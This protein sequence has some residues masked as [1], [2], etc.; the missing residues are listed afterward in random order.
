MALPVFSHFCCKLFLVI[1]QHFFFSYGIFCIFRNLSESD[2]GYTGGQFKN[3][4]L[5]FERFTILNLCK[6]KNKNFKLTSC[7][8]SFNPNRI[9]DAI[10]KFTYKKK[11]IRKSSSL[12]T[13]NDFFFCAKLQSLIFFQRD[14][15]NNNS[16]HSTRKAVNWIPL[17]REKIPPFLEGSLQKRCHFIPFLL[18][19]EDYSVTDSLFFTCLYLFF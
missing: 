9:Y 11:T 14:T 1:L 10:W 18:E 6:N 8:W 19:C 5:I 2:C 3:L 16:V 4:L 7:N 13:T 15:A 17:R 12:S